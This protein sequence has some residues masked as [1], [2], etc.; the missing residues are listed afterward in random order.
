M[1][2]LMYLLW[3]P[4]AQ[5]VAQFHEHCLHSLANAITRAG[6]R[7]VRCM[8][9]D[10]DVA[11]AGANRIISQPPP[12]DAVLSFWV[13]SALLAPQLSALFA[14][15]AERFCGFL[16]SES[17]PLRNDKFPPRVG[18]RT[19]GMNQVVLLQRPP[20]LTRE[21]WLHNWLV[22]HTPVAIE[23][24][25]SF[26][27][28][29]NVVVRPVTEPLVLCDAIVEENFPARAMNDREAFYAAEGDTALKI[30]REKRMIDSCLRFIDFDRIDCIPTS[31]Y[32][33]TA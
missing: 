28:R 27:Y 10:D 20:R 5:A 8:I 15:H 19:E 7:Q 9:A 2:K 21:E 6:G 4:T 32:V 1:E 17:E 11:A 29:Q 30:A 24:Q 31:E 23:T 33:V 3:K 12:F 25:S 13:D 18:Q 26:G 22:D 16:V 14:Q